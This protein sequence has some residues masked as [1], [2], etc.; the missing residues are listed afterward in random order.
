MVDLAGENDALRSR[1]ASAT[2]SASNTCC[3]PPAS[4]CATPRQSMPGSR[5]ASPVRWPLPLGA[6]AECGSRI[7]VELAP[8]QNQNGVEAWALQRSRATTP[9]PSASPAATPTRSRSLPLGFTRVP[10][11]QRCLVSPGLEPT[12]MSAR[13]GTPSPAP[14]EQQWIWL[15]SNAPGVRD[16]ATGASDSLLASTPA[17]LLKPSSVCR[18]SSQ[19][20]LR[21]HR[22]SSSA[23]FS[24]N[25]S[26]VVPTVRN[27]VNAGRV[28]VPVVGAAFGGG[29]RVGVHFGGPVIPSGASRVVN[30]LVV[31]ESNHGHAPCLVPSTLSVSPR[32]RV[33]VSPRKHVSPRRG[34]V[35]LSGPVI[36]GGV[37]GAVGGVF[38]DESHIGHAVHPA[39]MAPSTFSMLPGRHVSP[40]RCGSL[41]ERQTRKSTPS[42]M[43]SSLAATVAAAPLPYSA[44]AL[45]TGWTPSPPPGSMLS[46]P[47]LLSGLMPTPAAYRET[48][49]RQVDVTPP[50]HHL[51]ASSLSA[52][53]PSASGLKGPRILSAVRLGPPPGPRIAT[54]LDVAP[55]SVV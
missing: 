34:S 48:I 49:A 41:T 24:T 35:C 9:N 17:M 19:P 15:P 51:A 6:D 5:A 33:S 46:S 4:S 11:V 3:V 8:T 28:P 47:A 13:I 20:A 50:R 39:Q 44:A 31:E 25:P 27:E 7:L 52:V 38:A 29:P 2:A 36:P 22:A 23:R 37:C 14:P 55:R 10:A 42:L 16:A 53:G 18:A 43:S 21:P 32:R 40:G 45:H 26:V 1:L 12:T 54:T 30:N